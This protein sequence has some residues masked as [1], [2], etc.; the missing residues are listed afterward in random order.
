MVG[1]DNI[2][3]VPGLRVLGSVRVVAARGKP[4]T[5]PRRMTE[6][7]AYLA[8]RPGR[9][10]EEFSEAMWGEGAQLRRGAGASRNNYLA[11]ARGWLGT[12]PQDGHPWVALVPEWGYCLAAD[13]DVDWWRWCDLLGTGPTDQVPTSVL[14]Q[15]LSLVEGRPLSGIDGDR[16]EWAMT[17][18]TAMCD[19]VATACVVRAERAARAGQWRTVQRVTCLGLDVDPMDDALHALA[20]AAG[21]RGYLDAA[22]FAATCRAPAQNL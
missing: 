22:A 7:I 9:S 21:R 15:A 6:V 13:T 14:D 1:M 8:L 11:S 20:V 2:A 3:A 5:A 12:H 19:A 10:P 17:H 16:W 18:K 4:P